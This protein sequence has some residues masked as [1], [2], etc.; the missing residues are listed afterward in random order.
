MISGSL[1]FWPQ[2]ISSK[3]DTNNGSVIEANAA[4]SYWRYNISNTWTNKECKDIVKNGTT[5]VK[6]A[7]LLGSKGNYVNGAIGAYFGAGWSNMIKPF[8][9]AVNKNT[10]LT[11]S[12][13]WN[14]PKTGPVATSYASNTKIIYK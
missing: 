2:I 8:E 1:G 6:L 3:K 7:S 12:Y 9:N 5:M 14:I 13:T 11:I 10:G 4:D